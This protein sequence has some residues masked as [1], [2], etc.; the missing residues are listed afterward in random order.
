MN[1]SQA[2]GENLV[3]KLAGRLAGKRCLI[4]GGSRG[5]GRAMG[6]AF[7]REGARVAFTF[8]RN[9]ADADEA[10]A[11]LAEVSARQGTGEPRVFRGSVGDAGHARSG[12]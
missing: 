10:R 3:G 7:A 11:L 2:S 1:A 4:T 9:Q 12:V 6:L 8:S 5:L